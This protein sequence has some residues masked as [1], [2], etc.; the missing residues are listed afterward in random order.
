M[1]IPTWATSCG[2]MGRVERG[3][4]RAAAGRSSSTPI[5]SW[6]T[7][8][9][10]QSCSRTAG[11]HDEA[12]AAFAQ[13]RFEA[14]QSDAQAQNQLGV[15]LARRPAGSRKRSR[16][17]LRT[18][19]LKP[20]H[21]Q[22]YSNLGIALQDS[23]RAEEAIAAFRRA[24]ELNPALARTHVNLG[25]LLLDSGQAE[26]AMAQLRPGDP[27]PAGPGRGPLQPRH[28]AVSREPSRR[29]DRCV[30]PGDRARAR[31]CRGV[32]RPR[33]RRAGRG[34][35]RGGDPHFL[36]GPGAA[37]RL[38]HRALE[39]ADVRAVPAPG[40]PWPAWPA[41]TPSGTSGTPHR[42]RAELAS[43]GTSIATPSGRSASVSSPPTSAATRSASSWSGAREPRPAAFEVVCYH[44]RAD[45]DDLTDRLAAAADRVARR[46][47]GSPTMRW[48]IR[49]APT[50]STSSS[51][52]RATPATTG[53]WSSRAGRRR[54]RSPGSATSGR[55]AWRRWTT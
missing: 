15:S 32:Q 35:G 46:R 44:N 39:P 23:G 10:G 42:H 54:S 30:S 34:R 13:V 28:C 4:G 51:T 40:R 12:I 47:S 26:A 20:D 6:R 27:A 8:E 48:P 25:A 50:G 17:S 38:R 36:P 22:A 2:C 53:S 11:R 55:P 45:R 43:R 49:S 21:A 7:P 31:S 3:D 9:L 37:A 19:Q 24:I 5:M 1:P 33:R 16:R 29:G 14:D 52:C 18:I 41:P